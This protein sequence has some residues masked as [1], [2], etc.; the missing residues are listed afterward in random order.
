MECTAA[1]A[2]RDHLPGLLL[3]LI[4]LMGSQVSQGGGPIPYQC[5]GGCIGGK[6]LA[7]QLDQQLP[8]STCAQH[9]VKVVCALGAGICLLCHLQHHARGLPSTGHACL[10]HCM[11]PQ[12]YASRQTPHH[13]GATQQMAGHWATSLWLLILKCIH[14][15][16]GCC[17][18]MSEAQPCADLLDAQRFGS[19][20]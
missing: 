19:S 16:S 9:L 7:W 3:G 8:L 17:R 6:L 13:G 10:T 2:A 4:D 15:M 14:A 1:T 18:A 20:S 11:L 5:A 12:H